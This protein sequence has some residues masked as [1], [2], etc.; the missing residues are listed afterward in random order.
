MDGYKV[1]L[2][3]TCDP[4]EP[5]LI[6]HVETTPATTHDSKVV[7]T[8]HMD[9]ATVDL[10]P[11]EHLVDQGYVDTELL[12]TSQ[13]TH[14]VALIG[15]IP[16]DQSWQAT[17]GHGFALTDFAVD[18]EAGT[19]QCPTGKTSTAWRPGYRPIRR[20]RDP[21]ELRLGRLRSLSVS[22]AVHPVGYLGPQA[23]PAPPLR[24]TRPWS[25][26]A[27]GRTH[28]RSRLNT[29]PELALKGRLPRAPVCSACARRATVG[30]P[31]R[32]CSTS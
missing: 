25:P 32:I 4:D 24:N 12:L 10:L 31:R 20:P 9:L 13:T 21:R 22:L 2:T 18:W 27:S 11:A 17:A 23:H 16:A 8:I 29:P 14:G 26:P 28:K 30:Y 1:H 5:H 6:V 19:A 7:E 3:E 15:P